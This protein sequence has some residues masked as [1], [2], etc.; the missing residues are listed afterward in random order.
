MNGALIARMLLRLVKY[1]Y[2]I[3]I[4]DEDLAS[5]LGITTYE[6][7]K[8]KRGRLADSAMLR[9]AASDALGVDERDLDG[10]LREYCQ[11]RA[12]DDVTPE[13]ISI[14]NEHEARLKEAISLLPARMAL[15]IKLRYGIFGVRRQE[16]WVIAES[17]GIAK[18]RVLQIESEALETLRG[19]I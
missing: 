3:R 8:I 12:Q 11:I 17:L 14:R 16:A 10:I 7:R 9:E 5:E 13:E 18:K 15:V 6:L 1:G 19:M 4:T 2:G